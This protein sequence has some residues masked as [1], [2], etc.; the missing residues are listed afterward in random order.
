MDAA[1]AAASTVGVTPAATR[2]R[3]AA[4]R[5]S[6]VRAFW[7]ERPPVSYGVDMTFM[8]CDSL[9]G[10]HVPRTGGGAHE[11]EHGPAVPGPGGGGRRAPMVP[12]RRPAHLEGDVGGHRRR[13]PPLRGPGGPR[14]GHPAAPAPR[15]RRDD[16]RAGG[17]DP[18]AAARRSTGTPASRSRTVTAGA[19][20]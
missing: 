17:R 8:V 11:R 12:R 9:H 10:T 16:D 5:A 2:S 1:A 18:H 13:V 4:T 19:P 20:V 6:R 7:A 15:L 3:A 14:Q